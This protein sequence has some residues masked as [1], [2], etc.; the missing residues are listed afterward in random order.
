MELTILYS[1]KK[2]SHSRD[3][4]QHP[5]KTN[6]KGLRTRCEK[7]LVGLPDPGREWPCSLF[8][9]REIYTSEWEYLLPPLPR[10]RAFTFHSCKISITYNCPN[11]RNEQME[12]E[13]SEVVCPRSHREHAFQPE[14]RHWPLTLSPVFF[15]ERFWEEFW[16]VAG[17]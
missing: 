10:L 17:V 15:P 14:L 2:Y 5:R 16:E 9:E 7:S 11:F 1:H 8:P 3:K 12:T 4:R 13:R 6:Q